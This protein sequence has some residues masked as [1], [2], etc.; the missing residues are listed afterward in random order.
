[1]SSVCPLE[2]LNYK[3]GYRVTT[4]S[5]MDDPNHPGILYSVLRFCVLS[6]LCSLYIHSGGICADLE[7]INPT[8]VY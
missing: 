2:I 3:F 4:A 5:V 1:M 7:R 8:R 6:T